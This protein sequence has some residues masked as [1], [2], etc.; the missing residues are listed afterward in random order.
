M[1]SGALET[2]TKNDT[3]LARGERQLVVDMVGRHSRQRGEQRLVQ[4]CGPVTQKILICVIAENTNPSS[5]VSC[6]SGWSWIY[7]ENLQE[8]RFFSLKCAWILISRQRAMG[9]VCTKSK[10]FRILC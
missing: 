2:Q 5:N 7:L 4:A 6:V 8:G 3:N 1:S 10:I 9:N